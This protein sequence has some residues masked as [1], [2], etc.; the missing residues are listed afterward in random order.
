MHLHYLL[1]SRNADF[2]KIY[3]RL[4]A[5]CAK[6][7]FHHS[8][9]RHCGVTQAH[10]PDRAKFPQ[11]GDAQRPGYELPSVSPSAAVQGFPGLLRPEIPQNPE[12][13]PLRSSG[14]FSDLGQ[15]LGQARMA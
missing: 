12:V 14:I 4:G 5:N 11:S 8:G 9:N 7:L 6:A 13:V 10:D 15:S 2:T 1:P 3:P